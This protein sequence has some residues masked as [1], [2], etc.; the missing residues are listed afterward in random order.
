MFE[1]LVPSACLK[2]EG[3]DKRLLDEHVKAGRL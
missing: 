1:E 2:Q 3:S